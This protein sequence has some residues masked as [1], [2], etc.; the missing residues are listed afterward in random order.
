MTLEQAINKLNELQAAQHAYGHAMGVL[1]LDGDTAAPSA[2]ARGRSQT[3]GYLSGVT[4]QLLVNDEVKEALETILANK[5][6]VTPIQ[7]RQAELFK[8][9][10]DDS[11]RIPMAEYVEYSTLINQSNAVWHEAK[12]KNDYAAF[13]PYLE[14]VIAFNRKFAA[15][16]ND[17]KPAYDVLLDNYEKG[18]STATL[19]PFFSLLREKLSPV[20]LAVADKPAPEAGFLSQRF[21]IAD[22]RIFSDR[23]M[24]MMGIPRDRCGIAET[25]HPFTT[26]FNKWDVRITTNYSENNVADSMYSVIHEGGHALYE[27]GTADEIQFTSLAS[28]AS[29]G[30]HESQSRFYENIIG[31]SLPF[32]RALLPVMQ[33]I[34]PAQMKGVTAEGLYAAVNKSQPSLIRTQADELTY[35]MHIAIRYEM[36]KLMI[37]GDVKVDELPQLWNQMYK[38]YLGVTVPNDREGI[39]QDVHWSGGMIG[40]FP[41]YALGSAYGVQMLAAMEKEFDPWADVEKGDLSR[42]TAWLGEKIHRHGKMLTPPQLLRNAIHTDFDPTCYVNYLTKKFSDLYRL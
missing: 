23:L 11:V 41:S 4:Y 28:G 7:A 36:E 37:G 21:P 14:K 25:E 8:E 10:Y 20:I 32:C 19:D 2:S 22:Q 6:A 24:Q 39:L 29:M 35:G 26:N 12:G 9:D 42:V 16:K 5:E 34:F 27:L 13:A 33:E 1:S 31:R 17:K 30:L 40:Y 38:E 3:M 18:A 15:Y